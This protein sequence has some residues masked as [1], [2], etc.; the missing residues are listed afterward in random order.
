METVLVTGGTGFIGLHCLQQLLDKGYKVR[1]TIRSESRKQEVMEAMKKHSSNC[2][3]LEFFIADLLSDDGWSEAV[4]G[5]KYV[6]H[7]ASPFFLGEPENEDVFIK[8]AVE[9]T[10]R[11]LKACADSDVQKVVLTS[12]F[13]AVGY[14]HSREKEVYTEEDWSSVDGEISPY[15]KS[16]TL[17]EKAAW[18]FVENLEESKKFELTVINPVAVTGPMLTSDIGSSNDFLLKL[19]SGSMPACPKIHMG[20]IDVRDVA[21]AHIFSMTEEKTNG[22]RIIV[23]ENEMF[24]AEV[25]KTLNEA[26]FKKSPTKEMPN[27]LVKIMSLFVGELKTLLSALNRKGDIDKTKAKSFF[28][29]DFISTEKSVTETAQQLQDMGL[30]K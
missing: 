4:T 18:E 8:P 28:N 22:E 15:A 21:K 5:S 19:I 17:A 10:L 26:G 20:Y 7:V 2:E 23:S 24:F 27:F 1:T 14:G 3:N 16:K 29:W 30:T 25:G 12:S 6:L 9:G 11:V 13:A